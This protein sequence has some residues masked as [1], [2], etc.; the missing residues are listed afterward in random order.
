MGILPM[1]PHGRD[2]RA[3]KVSSLSPPW[4]FGMVGNASA[5]ALV[6]RVPPLSANAGRLRSLWLILIYHH[7]RLSRLN[8]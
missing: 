8:T 3:T 5:H 7:G 1:I 6:R 2:A 4:P